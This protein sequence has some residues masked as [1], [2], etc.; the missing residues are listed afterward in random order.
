M[1]SSRLENLQI[2]QLNQ[3][4]SSHMQQYG[5][6]PVDLPIIE[7]AD[8]FLIKAGDQIVNRL[9]TFE[10]HGRQL[11]LRPEFTAAA[12][13][14]YMVENGD[15]KPVARWQFGGYVFEDNPNNFSQ[16]NQRYSI[17]AE[18]I[19]MGSWIADAEII[20]MAAQGLIQEKIYGWQLTI[21]HIGL[22]RRALVQFNLDNRIEHFLLSHLPSLKQAD[23]G[24][25]FVLEQLD[26]MLSSNVDT[27]HLKSEW[28]EDKEY[29]LLAESNTQQILNIL[30]DTTHRGTTMGGRTRHDIARR[31]L[32]KRRRST[33]RPQV[34]TA[35]DFLMEWGQISAAPQEAFQ[36]ISDLVLPEDTLS[37]VLLTEWK[38]VIETLDAYG[39]PTDYIKIQPDLARFWD[40]YT[41][42]VFELR[43]TD[44]IHLGGGGR[45]DELS[46]LLGSKNNVPAVGFAYYV[47][48]F[49][50]LFPESPAMGPKN[51]VIC[52]DTST[53]SVGI[54]W[55]KQLRQQNFIVQILLELNLPEFVKTLLYA[56]ED[57]TLRLADKV[58]AIEKINLLTDELNRRLT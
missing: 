54:Q 52:V 11:A 34:I 57:G 49:M 42:V 32:Q 24:K 12:A 4:L 47:D 45:Y 13:Y 1:V 46:K 43:T 5:Y 23:L 41:G 40:Y 14:H 2:L 28:R 55:A 9:F 15:Q 33:E 35:I 20:S 19:G 8:L 51:I 10:Y 22:L 7:A 26:K 39:I 21:G 27:N 53:A 31:L 3:R 6:V 37:Q 50:S 58:Y 17:G 18:L 44:D 48:E 30:L 56:N 36:A 38:Q 25:P 29:N 16:N